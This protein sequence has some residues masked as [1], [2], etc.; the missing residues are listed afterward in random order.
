MC[1][2]CIQT[3]HMPPLW[4]MFYINTRKIEIS[5][6]QAQFHC[7]KQISSII[8]SI[9]CEAW[10]HIT[11]VHVMKAHIER[12][13]FNSFFSLFFFIFIRCCYCLC[14]TEKWPSEN[15]CKNFVRLL[16]GY[17]YFIHSIRAEC[18]R[19]FACFLAQ[20]SEWN[21]LYLKEATHHAN[22]IKKIVQMNE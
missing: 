15:E 16:V 5:I 20:C 1:T 2:Q 21:L 22:K 13:Q 3:S 11:F 18:V 4:F 10:K 12:N 7:L 14:Q 8:L 17:P 9:E 6:Y 19:L